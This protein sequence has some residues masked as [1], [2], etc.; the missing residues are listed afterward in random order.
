MKGDQALRNSPVDYFS[1]RRAGEEKRTTLGVLDGG[2][3]TSNQQQPIYKQ[4]VVNNLS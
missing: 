4:L 1:E 3:E 2:F